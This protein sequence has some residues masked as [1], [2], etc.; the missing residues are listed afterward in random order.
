MAQ[1]PGSG[2]ARFARIWRGRATKANADAYES[3]W[4]ATG[5]EPLKAK[6]AL[7]VEMLREERETEVEFVTISYWESI[8]AMTGGTGADPYRTHHLDRDAELLIELPERVQIL[9]ILGTHGTN[10]S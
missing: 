3:Y 7:R 5:I 8:E 9:S 2:Q 4:L 10:L 6:G 1:K